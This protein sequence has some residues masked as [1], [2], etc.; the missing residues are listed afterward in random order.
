M[1]LLL[2]HVLGDFYFQP[3]TMAE[4]K[5]HSWKWLVGHGVIYAI[6]MSAV[7]LSGVKYSQNLLYLLLAAVVSHIVVDYFKRFIKWK[8][9]TIDQLTHLAILGVSWKIWGENLPTRGFVLFEF[10]YFKKSM[11]LVILGLLCILQPVGTLI[12]RGDIWDFDKG[13]TSPNES[14]KGA[15]KMR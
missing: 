13:K 5:Y 8:R 11:I 3:K 1:L 2:G 6:S 14:Q 15:G 9:F 12:E 10:D 7:L 4:N